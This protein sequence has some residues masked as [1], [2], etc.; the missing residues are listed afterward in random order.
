MLNKGCGG[1][2][3]TIIGAINTHRDYCKTFFD[4]F[5]SME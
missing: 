5:N 3:C 1:I 4:I 2:F